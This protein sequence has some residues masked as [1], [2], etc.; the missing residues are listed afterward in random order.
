[1]SALALFFHVAAAA[2]S[3]H[4]FFDP[5]GKPLAQF[6]P[7]WRSL[8]EAFDE[9]APKRIVVEFTESEFS[10][11]DARRDRILIRLGY[12]PSQVMAKIAHESAHL[13]AHNLTN[14]YSTQNRFRFIDE[15]FA[16][17]FEGFVAGKAN[18][19]KQHA[20][21]VAA[22]QQRVGNVR[23]HLVQDWLRYWGDWRKGKGQQTLYAYP[24]GASFVYF[25]IDQYGAESPFRL[26]KAIGE[27]GNFDAA[28]RIS[29]QR[30]AQEIEAGWI[31]YLQAVKITAGPV[32][33]V[34]MNPANGASGVRPDLRELTVE[35]DVP[36][37]RN[38]CIGTKRCDEICYR[39]AHRKSSSVLTIKL[40]K[41]LRPN[42]SYILWL[43]VRGRCQL[44]SVAM[45]ELPV[46]TWKFSTGRR[47]Q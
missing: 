20:L 11:F 25:L 14:G 32:N 16:S 34:R 15:G 37:A 17:V 21:A 24:V 27:T 18:D 44:K 12:S 9:H 1:M 30:S 23:L 46:T 36:M 29:L 31:G 3:T 13:A 10:R 7:I 39:N 6:E 33:I 35:F 8:H 40:P 22:H 28:T 26:M 38:I 4:H 47:S 42:S 43:G 45:S 2:E 19:F 41:G 5:A